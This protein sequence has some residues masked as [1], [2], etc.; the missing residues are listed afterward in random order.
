MIFGRKRFIGWAWESGH[1]PNLEV[2]IRLSMSDWVHGDIS[3]YSVGDTKCWCS[4]MGSTESR[5]F[6]NYYSEQLSGRGGDS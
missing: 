4:G 5:Y 6:L 3:G 1:G 2:D